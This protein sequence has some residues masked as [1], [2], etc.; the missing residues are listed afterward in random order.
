VVFVAVVL[1]LASS[2]LG[3]YDRIEHWGKFVHAVDGLCATLLFG[4]LLL[5]WR[6]VEGVDLADELAGLMAVCAGIYFGVMW[7][8]V[9]FV[10]DWVSYS[11]LQKS[12]SDTMTDLLWN[13][14]GAAIA[15]V[16]ATHMYCHWLTLRQRQDL[17]RVA[18]WLV[19]GPSRLLD[20]HGFL[21][22]LVAAVLMAAAV[23]AV[24][25][26]GRPLPGLAIS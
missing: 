23:A 17:S 7:E 4:V 24:W 3:L 14:V 18:T 11:D 15:A 19:G 1:P 5:A 26:S 10:I 9:E 6:H 21:M 16:L 2:L 13:D 20:R 25:F 22:T 8:I 12:N